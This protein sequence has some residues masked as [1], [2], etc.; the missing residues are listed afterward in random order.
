LGGKLLQR[1]WTGRIFTLFIVMLIGFTCTARAM[2]NQI[3]TLPSAQ[4]RDNH[5]ICFACNYRSYIILFFGNRMALSPYA[6]K[7]I[8]MAASYDKSRNDGINISGFSN[9]SRNENGNRQM[10]LKLVNLVRH[11]LVLDGVPT[12]KMI[13]QT[14]GAKDFIFPKSIQVSRD[15]HNYVLIN[16]N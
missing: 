1:T 8:A 2:P 5:A 11:Q 10:S 3:K 6:I 15:L 14:F 7:I 12:M 9:F 16:V 4:I 13:L